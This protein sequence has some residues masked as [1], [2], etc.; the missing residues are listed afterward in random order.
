MQHTPLCILLFSLLLSLVLSQHDV[1]VYTLTQGTPNQVTVLAGNSSGEVSVV[2]KVNT[3][4]NGVP[5][6]IYIFFNI[7][8][9]H[10]LKF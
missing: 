8:R 7:L 3:G 10:S 5:A 2:N 9:K 4:G 6:G 1:A